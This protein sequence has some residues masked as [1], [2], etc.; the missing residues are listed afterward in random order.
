MKKLILSNV[1]LLLAVSVFLFSCSSSDPG[2]KVLLPKA[3]GFYIYGT[4]TVASG[5]SELTARMA[6]AALDFTKG[7]KVATLDS[8]YG[9]YLYIGAGSKISFANVIDEKGTIY[10]ADGGGAIDSAKDVA[11]SP[12]KD[13]VIHGTLKA[14]A[15]QIAIAEEGLYYAYV[16]LNTA[17]FIIMKVRANMIGDATVKQWAGGTDLPQKSSTKDVTVFEGTNILLTKGNGYRY[18][19]NDGWAIYQD[20][21]IITYNSLGVHDWGESWAAQVNNLVFEASNI[22]QSVGSGYYT[23]TLTYTASTGIW[24]ETKVKT[25]DVYSQYSIGIIGD[26]TDGGSFNGDGTGGYE[27]K[28][29]T[30]T[31][32]NYTWTWSNVTFIK[33]KEF[34][35]LQ[36]ATWGKFLVAYDGAAVSGTS[37]DAGDV[38]DAT[39][40]PVNSPYHNFHVINGGAVDVT[41]T[42]NAD[43]DA[44]TVVINKHV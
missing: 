26:A 5:P 14:N 16:N 24:S 41:L 18:R 3:D 7:P 20:D 2:P 11:N 44:V 39:A 6:L 29:P 31:G 40:D 13:K 34:V 23:V 27:V 15:E 42:V 19:M 30:K 32:S 36:N 25:G 22:P 37:I 9:K 4:N 35:F 8:V 17:E 1:L 12:I 21:N 43:T 10:G 28:L 38:I 33:D